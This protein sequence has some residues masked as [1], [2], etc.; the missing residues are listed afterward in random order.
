MYVIGGKYPENKLRS[1]ISKQR[2]SDSGI[3]LLNKL[4]VP[5]PKKRINAEKALRHEWFKGPMT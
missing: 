4:L 5:Y 2:L 1:I 3:D